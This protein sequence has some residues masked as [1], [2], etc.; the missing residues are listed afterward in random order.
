MIRLNVQRMTDTAT[1]PTQSNPHDA[2]F[3]MYAAE[4]TFVDPGETVM[5]STGIKVI[6]EFERFHSP[7]DEGLGEYYLIELQVRPRSGN[8]AKHG[9]TVLNSPGTV[10]EG[11]RG[12]V[13]VILHNAGTER[14][15]VKQGDR[16]AQLVPS[17]VPKT[18][19]KEIGV[20]SF[21]SL[22]LNHRASEERAA[23]GFGSTGR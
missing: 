4:D 2:G 11:Y 19:V 3:D 16:I 6:P 18:Y 17:L 23:A 1:I 21:E 15:F 22:S 14:F 8:A 7:F 20:I 5:V 9:V 13:K 10:D 12:E